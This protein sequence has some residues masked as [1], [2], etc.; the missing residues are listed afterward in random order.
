[1]TT[2]E[3]ERSHQEEVF[4]SVRKAFASH[5]RELLHMHGITNEGITTVT[6]EGYRYRCH[7]SRSS[8]SNHYISV[9]PPGQVF[10]RTLSV[11][12]SPPAVIDNF[13]DK[14]P[15]IRSAFQTISDERVTQM[16]ARN[17]TRAKA[18]ER[19]L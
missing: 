19:F 11:D 2:P 8:G 18:V 12:S 14:W 10:A 3:Q 5:V 15:A 4:A 6:V 16:N 7:S 1:L 13:L 9:K 17:A